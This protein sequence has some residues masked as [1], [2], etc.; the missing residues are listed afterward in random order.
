M[1][2]VIWLVLIVSTIFV[3]PLIN[4]RLS[5]EINNNSVI[6]ALDHPKFKLA[7]QFNFGKLREYGISSIILSEKSFEGNNSDM[8]EKVNGYGVQIILNLN[9]LSH[10]KNYYKNLESVIQKY[11]IRYLMMYNPQIEKAYPIN[12]NRDEDFEELRSL[13]IRNNLIFFVM[14]NND[15]TGYMPMPGLDLLI[16]GT[17][18]SLNRAFTVSNHMS[19]TITLQNASM[20]WYRA[21]VDRNVRLLC[22]EPVISS[23][24]YTDDNNISGVFEVSKEL[25]GRLNEKGFTVNAP[26]KKVN[27]NIPGIPWR[28]PVIVNLIASMALLI[29]YSGIKRPWSTIILIVLSALAGYLIF[30]FTKPETTIWE[31]YAAAIIYPSLA[32]IVLINSLKNPLGNIFIVVLRSLSGLF[33]IT[34]IGVCIVI[35]SMCD[36]RY[37]MHLINFNLVIPSFI[38]PIIVF[39]INFVFMLHK[40]YPVHK[41]VIEHIRRTGIKRYILTTLIYVCITCFLIYIYLVRSGDFNVLPESAAEIKVREFLELNMSA[42]P[43]IKEFIIGYPCMFAFLYLYPKRVPYKLISFLGTFSSIIG[44]SIINSF[45]HGFTPIMTSIN[46]TFNGLLLGIIT[47]CISLVI[48]SNLLKY[49]DWKRYS[50]I[51]RK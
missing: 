29:D 4:L 21:V 26:L 24:S 2:K 39:N 10:S 27:P 11:G 6:L 38:I 36:V 22:I 45:C 51:I 17:N 37:T 48:C 31:A 43:R 9:S 16:T 18:Y 42:R 12:Q 44:I 15:Q 19:E 7:N 41:R 1:R 14:E 25:A 30:G 3:A 47:G 49:M 5:N 35:S 13:I 50:Y 32:G 40:Q 23:K 34:G 20:M 28:L 8:L 46:R 33:L